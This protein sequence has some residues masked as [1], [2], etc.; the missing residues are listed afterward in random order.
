MTELDKVFGPREQYD[1][2]LGPRLHRDE[3]MA[4]A[5]QGGT[6]WHCEERIRTTLDAFFECWPGIAPRSPD[7][8]RMH[9]AASRALVDEVGEMEAP[10]FVRWAATVV[11]QEA[12]RLTVKTARSLLFLLGRWRAREAGPEWFRKPC[13][14]CSTI[15]APGTCPENLED[16][17]D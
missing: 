6:R 4:K 2:T 16:E 5:L 9:Y 13:P 8:R 10:A 11:R 1:P 15:H 7:G 12:P 14:K 17:D 3:L